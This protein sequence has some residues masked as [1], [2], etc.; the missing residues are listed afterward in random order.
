MSNDKRWQCT[1]SDEILD[2]IESNMEVSFVGEVLEISD[3]FLP[4]QLDVVFKVIS[5]SKTLSKVIVYG[6]YED[7]PLQKLY[8]VL[9]ENSTI[10]KLDTFKCLVASNPTEREA[11]INFLKKVNETTLNFVLICRIKP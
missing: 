1:A 4:E 8:N 7:L 2:A 9:A 6:P 3:E 11:L 5:A 10:K